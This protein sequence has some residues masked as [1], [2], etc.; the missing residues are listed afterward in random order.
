[1]SLVVG[2]L[3]TL[4]LLVGLL[5]VGWLAGAVPGAAVAA[6]PAVT[7]TCLNNIDYPCYARGSFYNGDAYGGAYVDA[8]VQS[9]SASGNPYLNETLWACTNSSACS[10][11]AEIGY[12]DN[13]PLCRGSF[14]WYY[15]TVNPD[16]TK[17]ACFGSTPS[18]GSYYPLEVQE[19]YSD[20]YDVY[21]DGS[22]VTTDVGTSGWVYYAYTGLEWHL[23][24]SSV[25]GDA[26]FSAQELRS[27]GCCSWSY[28]PAGGSNVSY[29]QYY[30][31]AWTSTNPWD[32]GYDY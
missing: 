20:Q 13:S 19:E 32:N 6:T 9:L 14:R 30:N 5:L 31:W 12:T 27:T 3:R 24:P 23:L 11:W 7:Q 1:M 28:W 29:S 17:Q 2:K 18:V 22:L 15:T 26:V 16:T 8:K 25:G 4:V 10:Y 21:L